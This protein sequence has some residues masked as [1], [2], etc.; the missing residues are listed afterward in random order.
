MEYTSYLE[1]SKSALAQNFNYIYNL[2][3][4]NCLISHVVKGNAY[5]HG[6]S[7]FVPLARE[8]GAQHFSTFDA[9]EAEQVHNITNGELPVMIMGMITNDQL[10]WAIENEIEF[11]IFESDRLHFAIEAAKKQGKKALV[12]LEL[13]TGMNRTGLATDEVMRATS[14]IKEN[15]LHVVV[16]GFCT[17]YA[18]AESIGNFLRVEKQYKAF[19]S[20]AKQ[21]RANGINAEKDH[22]ACSA[23]SVR[24][25]K[26]RMDMVRIGILQYGFWPSKETYITT[27][28]PKTLEDEDPLKRVLS[29]K[30]RIMSVK[31]VKQGEYIGYGTSYLAATDI[32]MATVPV[33]YGYG[34]SRSL[35]NSGRA[36]VRGKRVSVIGTVNMNV[37]MLDVTSLDSVEKGDEVVLIGKQ[38]DL[39][40]TVSSFSEFSDQMNYELLT[41]LPH[42][43]TRKIVD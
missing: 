25:P 38:G 18:G 8:L 27:I 19:N 33:G 30:S 15:Q 2:M 14:L 4:Q 31:T 5:G 21:L 28:Q 26:T 23:A 3:G 12:H 32:K 20:I 17:H 40:L 10:F 43:I 11:F 36:L 22:T 35:S 39:D 37:M 6:I 34:F 29:W 13:E 1:L 41:R 16:K 7:T 24:I 9:M 42:G